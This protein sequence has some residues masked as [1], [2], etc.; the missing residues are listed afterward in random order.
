MLGTYI[1]IMPYGNPVGYV[2][3]VNLLAV[4]KAGP[5]TAGPGTVLGDATN[6]RLHGETSPTK[7]L[8]PWIAFKELV[9]ATVYVP[10]EPEFMAVDTA[11]D[12]V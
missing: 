9:D 3:V 12:L 8:I 7:Y 10:P 4:V 2:D 6:I 11:E 5:T 1:E